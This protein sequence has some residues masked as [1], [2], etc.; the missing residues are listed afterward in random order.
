MK[1]KGVAWSAG[2]ISGGISIGWSPNA[3]SPGDLAGKYREI[4]GSIPIGVGGFG[5]AGYS[6]AYSLDNPG[7]YLDML[8]VGVGVGVD[9]HEYRGSAEVTWSDSW[10][11]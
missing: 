10:T 7:V 4:G 6:R 2:G 1:S 3:Q 8:T 5:S 11:D 9:Y